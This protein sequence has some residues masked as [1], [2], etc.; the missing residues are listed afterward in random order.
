MSELLYMFGQLDARVMPLIF[1]VRHWAQ[2]VGLTNPSP[3]RWISNFSLTCLVIFYLQQLPAP[4]L[5]AVNTLIANARRPEDVRITEDGINCSFLRDLRAV[6]ELSTQSSSRTPNGS[7]LAELLVGF[8]E[9]CAQ[10]DFAEHAISL[11]EA[12]FVCKPDHS[13]VYIVNPLEAQLNVSKN[14]SPEECERFRIEVRNAAW[15]LDSFG[16]PNGDGAWG[17]LSIAR[18]TSTAIGGGQQQ[19]Q[20]HIRPNMFF[21]SRMVDVSDLFA[22]NEASDAP[23]TAS[24]TVQFKNAAVRGT[25]ERIQRKG[26]EDLQKIANQLNGKSGGDA[27]GIASGTFPSRLRKR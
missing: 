25:V 14:I 21:R 16:E 23:T 18:A 11:N 4:I 26:R 19:Q 22:A 24:Q 10:M 15:S 8:F 9:F 3:G 17:V 1:T 12:R 6:R 5:P 27:T 2:C 13:A 7:G 20:Q